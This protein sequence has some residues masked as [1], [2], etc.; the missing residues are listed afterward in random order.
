MQL[1]KL[2]IFTVLV[3]LVSACGP[4]YQTFYDFHPLKNASER[5][6]GGHCLKDKQNC[7]QMEQLM[8]REC[9]SRAELQ[10]QLCETRKIYGYDKKGKWECVDNCYCSRDSCSEN[11]ERCEEDYRNCY[12]IC[13]GK[14][15]ATTRCTSN[16]EEAAPPKIETLD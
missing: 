2:C 15:T 5:N 7:R 6:C 10:Y 9:E 13:G 16:C 11:T 1:I 14:I 4:T 8:L 12:V 3:I